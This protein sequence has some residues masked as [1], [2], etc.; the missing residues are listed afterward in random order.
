MAKYAVEFKSSARKEL[1]SLSDRLITRALT[2]IEN[3]SDDPRPPGS[4][5][6]RGYKDIWRVR[7]GDYRIVYIIDDMEKLVSI[8][9]VAH[10]KAVYE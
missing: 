9:R 5:K 4:K 2:K 3:L 10:R 6:L 7:V 8:T 1:E